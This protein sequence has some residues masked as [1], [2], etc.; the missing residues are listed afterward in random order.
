MADPQDFDNPTDAGAGEQPMD[1][2]DEDEGADDGGFDDPSASEGE[3]ADDGVGEFAEDDAVEGD[4][5]VRAMKAQIETALSQQVASMASAGSLAESAYEGAGNIVGV[6]VGS[7]ADGAFGSGPGGEVVNV[8]VAEPTSDDTVRASLSESFGV[9]EAADDNAPINVV[10]TGEIDV[11]PHRFRARPAPC[12]I[13]VGHHKIT[14][15]TIGALARARTANGKSCY[16]RGDR[17]RRVLLLSNNHVLANSNAGKCGDAILQPGPYDGGKNPADRIAVLERWVK[18]H[19]DG[20]PNLVDCAVGWTWHKRVRREFVYLS[21]GRRRL[22]RVN[23]R[24]VPC[25]VGMVVGKSGRTTQ[26][27]QGRIADCSATIRVN[28]GGGRVA[29]FRDQMGIRGLRGDFSAGGDSGSLIWTWDARRNPV[30]LLFAGG[31]G[32]TFANKIG[33]VLKALDI[34]LWT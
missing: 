13:S 22:F 34:N 3:Q 18:I 5:R 4:D 17:R 14:A 30:G 8:Y 11:Q 27:T 10:V 20:R 6:G 26:L 33:H 1:E 25:R 7:D 32:W 29:L 9:Q 23:S 16:P 2:F 15:G 12:G 21:G 24:P 31:G 28:F 19:F